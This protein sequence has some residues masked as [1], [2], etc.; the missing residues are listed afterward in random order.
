MKPLNHKERSS[1]FWQFLF[2][3]SATVII[4]LFALNF[5]FELPE[6][7][8]DFEKKQYSETKSFF[9]NQKSIL[10]QMDV[11]D[12]TIGQM[13]RTSNLALIQSDAIT[14]IAKL[15]ELSR[16]GSQDTLK[17]SY[18]DRIQKLYRKQ[19]EVKV[20]AIASRE[21]ATKNQAML[22]QKN[23][24]LRDCKNNTPRFIQ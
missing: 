16:A 1:L 6:K 10:A 3:F 15:G 2:L 9:R 21:A 22:E 14:A 13:G 20:D 18:I 4:V 19:V 7:L 23:Q 24:E 17:S 12:S 11:I 8:N 5:D